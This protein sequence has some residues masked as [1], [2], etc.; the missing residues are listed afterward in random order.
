M[1]D[2]LMTR[3]QR[4]E[5]ATAVI[6]HGYASAPD[7]DEDMS[8]LSLPCKMQ[9]QAALLV[10]ALEAVLDEM[11]LE[12]SGGLGYLLAG[13]ALGRAHILQDLASVLDMG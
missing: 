7:D 11:T 10:S 12:D 3:K 9:R 13:E 4:R 6:K 1:I 8:E 5:I 2:Q